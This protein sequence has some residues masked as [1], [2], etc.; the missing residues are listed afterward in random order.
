MATTLSSAGVKLV[1]GDTVITISPAP[2][3]GQLPTK[4]AYKARKPRTSTGRPVG[5]PRKVP[6]GQPQEP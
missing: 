3:N 1:I 2:A 5:R 6:V 4:R